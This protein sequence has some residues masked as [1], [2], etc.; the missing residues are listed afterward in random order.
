MALARL[1]V[2]VGRDAEARKLLRDNYAAFTQGFQLPDL[3]DGK[4]LLDSLS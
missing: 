3:V 4:H 2:G 1:H